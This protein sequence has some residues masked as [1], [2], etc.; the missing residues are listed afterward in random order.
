M[1]KAVTCFLYT[2]LPAFHRVGVSTI[3]A[4]IFL[5]AHLFPQLRLAALCLAAHLKPPI[6]KKY[7]FAIASLYPHYKEI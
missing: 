3:Q 2:R 5:P 7:K 4:G 6:G 1:P